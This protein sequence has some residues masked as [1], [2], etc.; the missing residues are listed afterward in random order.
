[1]AAL[2]EVMHRGEKEDWALRNSSLVSTPAKK[3]GGSHAFWSRLWK[4]STTAYDMV[5]T[6]STSLGAN[7]FILVVLLLPHNALTFLSLLY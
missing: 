5:L 4:Y 6:E 2:A 7:L 1:M 3:L